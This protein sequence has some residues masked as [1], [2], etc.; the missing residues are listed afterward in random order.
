VS[1][2]P[3]GAL[4]TGW[5]PSADARAG[6]GPLAGLRVDDERETARVSARQLTSIA[7]LAGA[8]AISMPVLEVGNPVGL[9]LVGRPGDDLSL[10]AAA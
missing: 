3:L 7:T 6:D 4:I 2:D 10:L 8:R 9:S 5:E 1:D